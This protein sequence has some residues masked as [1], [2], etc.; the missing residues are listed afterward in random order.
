MPEP[1]GTIGVA[2]A[3]H[4]STMATTS[5]VA[6]GRTTQR[7]RVAAACRDSSWQSSSLISLPAVTR[8]APSR[9]RRAVTTSASGTIMTT[10]L[11]VVRMPAG[12]LAAARR[13]RGAEL[14]DATRPRVTLERPALCVHL[15]EHRRDGREEPRRASPSRRVPTT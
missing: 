14:G 15:V 1:L 12:R 2:C 8:S 9:A 10:L 3:A 5:D 7:G 11:L 6:A 13:Q 4:T